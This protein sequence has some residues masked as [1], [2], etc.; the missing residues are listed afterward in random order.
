MCTKS[1]RMKYETCGEGA[2]L[3]TGRETIDPDLSR[4]NSMMAV[5]ALW[6]L[7][8]TTASLNEH[9]IFSYSNSFDQRLPRRAFCG[10]ED[11]IH[12][13]VS[14]PFTHMFVMENY[15]NVMILEIIL[16]SNPTE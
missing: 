5:H 16:G 4:H 15:R 8:K 6:W 14:H 11:G 7:T 12:R 3:E 2:Q 10:Y 9:T 13:V 1:I